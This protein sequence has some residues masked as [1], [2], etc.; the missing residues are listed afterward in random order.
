MVASSIAK[1]ADDVGTAPTGAED[2]GDGA[3]PTHARLPATAA[4]SSP[5]G[6]ISRF[7]TL[8][9]VTS[10][11]AGIVLERPISVNAFPLRL[12]PWT[13]R[14]SWI[15]VGNRMTEIRKTAKHQSL[16]RGCQSG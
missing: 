11:P 4:A 9:A 6:N 1:A 2:P 10:M 14:A 7:R 13:R 8:K 15:G 16:R 3:P 12:P 5:P